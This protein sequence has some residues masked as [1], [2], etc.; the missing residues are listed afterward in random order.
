MNRTWCLLFLS[1]APAALFGQ[2]IS[3]DLVGSVQDMSGAA[4][5]NA[6]VDAVNEST[7]MKSSTRSDANGAYRFS[8]L[9]AGRYTLSAAAP[10]FN[11]ASL[12]GVTLEVSKIAT[13]NL[14]LQVGQVSSSI[15]VTEAPAN[16]DTTT[17]T[18]G[19]S[20]DARESRDLPISS[21]GL[22]VVNL[23]LLNAGV[24]SNGGLQIGRGPSVGGQRPRN[25]NFTIEGVDNNNKSSTGALIV[26]PNDATQE[27]TLLQNQFSAEFGHSSGGQFNVIVKSGTNDLHGSV[28]EYLQ[29]RKLNAQ[30]QLFA[31]SG[32]LSNPRYDNNRFGGTIGGPIVKD[33]LFYFGN[34]EYNPVGQAST[35]GQILTPTQNGYATLAGI[36]GLSQTNLG[37][38]KQFAAPAATPVAASRFPL[39]G[40]VPVEVGV[41]TIAAP[42]YQN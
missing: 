26:I 15:D 9:P 20:F 27:F 3:G 18:I 28:Y 1:L 39:V 11:P 14:T 13:V 21:I 36:S 29:N 7:N 16:I 34:Y 8:N 24:A 30:D 10:G 4:V 19:S 23:S 37:I 32:T 2:A 42:N 35:P 5:T 31:N 22:G 40:G 38:L 17:A 6:A 41:L 25:N 33:K 12:K